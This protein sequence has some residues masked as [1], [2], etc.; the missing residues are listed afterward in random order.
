M[1]TSSRFLAAVD[2][3]KVDHRL[4]SDRAV[5][6]KVGYNQNYVSQVRTAQHAVS[7]QALEKFCA[8]FPIS[9][10]WLLSGQG[11]MWLDLAEQA[12]AAPAPAP[13]SSAPPAQVVGTL[14]ISL[15]LFKGVDYDQ[16]VNDCVAFLRKQS[17]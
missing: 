17:A 8:Q 11:P 1:D 4:R 14:T 9:A 5:S 2:Q 6:L 12:I 3:I 16:L 13:T 7:V 10:Q 15:Q